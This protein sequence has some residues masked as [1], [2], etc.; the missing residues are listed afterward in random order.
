MTGSVFMLLSPLAILSRSV[1]CEDAYMVESD[2]W[3][4]LEERESVFCFLSNLQQLALL[5][6]NVLSITWNPVI[7]H[8]A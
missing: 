3:V 4:S 1:I 7:L 2:H 6:I 5:G 8:L